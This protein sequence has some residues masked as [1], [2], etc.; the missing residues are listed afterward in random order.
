[1][2]AEV[3]AWRVVWYRRRRGD[4]VTWRELSAAR[5]ARRVRVK[6]VAIYVGGW[7]NAPTDDAARALAAT[8]L[9][10]HGAVLALDTRHAFAR[11]YAAAAQRVPAVARGLADL[12]VALA[13]YGVSARA[14]HVV[15]F[16]L[17]AHAAG[18]A[19]RL[20]QLQGA[21]LG[22]ITALDPARPCFTH[23]AR[24]E[25]LRHGDARFVLAVHSSSGALGLARALG[26][27]DV[28]VNGVA[29]W[30]APCG[31]GGARALH[32][33]HNA[34][35]RAAAA[36]GLRARR[37]ADLRAAKARRCADS[38]AAVSLTTVPETM[39]GIY[40][41]EWPGPTE[42][43]TSLSITDSVKRQP[44]AGSRTK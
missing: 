19:G 2:R 40:L 30:Q 31:E 16:S 25:R 5:V 20:L 21:R 33:A 36:E 13:R 3:G 29:G 27:V 17:G 39:H 15:G 37:C 4:D 44:F 32:C 35:W 6:S 28:Y 42:S 22:R 41:L 8:L 14:L 9:H 43:N 11:G 12:C 7:G 23:E 1:M 10:N 34:S 38:S 24:R 26:N 18:A